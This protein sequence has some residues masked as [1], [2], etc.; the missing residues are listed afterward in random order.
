VASS[1]EHLGPSPRMHLEVSPGQTGRW[2]TTIYFCKV[3][4]NIGTHTCPSGWHT[5]HVVIQR[6]THI[7]GKPHIQLLCKQKEAAPPHYQLKACRKA[8]RP[9]SVSW[10]HEVL[11]TIIGPT[12]HSK[13]TSHI[14]YVGHHKLSY[15][16]IKDK[17]G[18]PEGT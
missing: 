16:S 18:Q 3:E 10:K 5:Y 1:L 15:K 14:N 17:L 12:I 8:S 4:A 11:S 6:W 13:W 9:S 2:Y 7:S